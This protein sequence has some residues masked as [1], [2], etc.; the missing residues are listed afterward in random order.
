MADFSVLD[1]FFWLLLII[2][3]VM[4]AWA[5]IDSLTVPQGAYAAASKLSKKLWMIITIVAAVVGG[6]Y[7]AAPAAL[8][9]HPIGLLLGI[10]PV[11]AFI[12]AAVYLADVRPAVAPFRKRG[13]GRG[14]TNMGPYGPW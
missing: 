11:A 4:E 7:A 14:N 12:A 6:A 8:G 3:F 13:G 9:A 1:Y 2:A 10:L 5:L